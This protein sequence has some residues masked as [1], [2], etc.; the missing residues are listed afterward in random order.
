MHV[1]PEAQPMTKEQFRQEALDALAFCVSQ[2]AIMRVE[3][4]KYLERQ[5]REHRHCCQ[6][7]DEVIL[8]QQERDARLQSLLD[9]LAEEDGEWWKRGEAPPWT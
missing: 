4:S 6:L 8:G 3:F 2:L 9:H 7:L 1:T 5:Q